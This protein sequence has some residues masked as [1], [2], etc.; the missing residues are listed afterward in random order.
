MNEYKTNIDFQLGWI[1]ALE[2]DMAMNLDQNGRGRVRRFSLDNLV[3]YNRHPYAIAL[4]LRHTLDT[5]TKG[6]SGS[7]SRYNLETWRYY[8]NKGRER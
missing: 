2:N 8:A 1:I 7:L 5:E 4:Q 3:A 6:I